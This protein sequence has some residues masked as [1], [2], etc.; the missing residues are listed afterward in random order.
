MKRDDEGG[1][2]LRATRTWE[3]ARVWEK[4]NHTSSPGGWGGLRGSE[5]RSINTSLSPFCPGLL[6]PP[7]APLV[8][9]TSKGTP[10]GPRVFALSQPTDNK[11]AHR[12][13]PEPFQSLAWSHT[14][15]ELRARRRRMCW[16]DPSS[17]LPGVPAPGPHTQ[18]WDLLR[19]APTSTT[20][21]P[22]PAKHPSRVS[23]CPQETPRAPT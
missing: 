10:R 6:H 20:A 23:T 14:T 9:W 18:L 8:P 21:G 16:C 12:P 17:L 13:G 7:M 22:A 15:V 1:L 11:P 2:L 3:R 4:H 5:D 19:M